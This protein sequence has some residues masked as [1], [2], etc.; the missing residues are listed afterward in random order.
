[1]SEYLISE[2][3]LILFIGLYGMAKHQLTEEERAAKRL[4]EENTSLKESKASAW[5][6]VNQLKSQRRKDLRSAIYHS[7]IS[8][9]TKHD[10][11]ELTQTIIDH[12]HYVGDIE[13]VEDFFKY[14]FKY[15]VKVALLAKD[16]VLDVYYN[17]DLEKYFRIAKDGTHIFISD[18]EVKSI[19]NKDY[20][21]ILRKS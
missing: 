8:T 11:E 14:D 19:T 10:P 20:S 16:G 13:T 6:E 15:I 4:Q 2:L 5:Q 3:L 12:L 17:Y 18:E 1:M 7:V 21:F 9:K